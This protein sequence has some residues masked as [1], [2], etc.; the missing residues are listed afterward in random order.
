MSE[1][2]TNNAASRLAAGIGSGDTS[3]TV[4]TG[5]GALFPSPTGG[6][7]FRIVLVNLSSGEWEI[8]FCTAR[9]GDVLTI[10]RAQEDAV[11]HPARAFDA[12][13]PVELRP[14]AGF[15]SSLTVTTTNI[16][17]G[18]Y[19]YGTDTGAANV[20]TVDLTPALVGNPPPD[21]MEVHFYAANSNTT[22][23]TLNINGQGAQQIIKNSGQLQPND[24]IANR[25]VKV[26]WNPGQN[27]WY[28]FSDHNQRSPLARRA[29]A[30]LTSQGPIAA[31]QN[32]PLGTGRDV[33]FNNS[34]EDP[35]NMW[36][37]VNP[38]RLTV[39]SWANTVRC[40]A[41]VHFTDAIDTKVALIRKH[42]TVGTGPPDKIDCRQTG[43]GSVLNV[44][45]PPWPVNAGDYFTLIV[46][47]TVDTTIDVLGCY[48]GNDLIE[49]STWL[50]VEVL[51]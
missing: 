39:P 27:A 12:D 30:W 37:A 48:T 43:T 41:Q 44:S 7:F 17:S 28:L 46:A 9:S 16:Q 15:F 38:E 14:T 13:D 19:N 36:S 23:S 50:S 1:L 32:I 21:G 3:L 45:S 35:D 40:T 8:A 31:N 18:T 51:D 33:V 34:Y 22:A 6:D 2:F 25:L 42:Y 20:Y 29:L 49:S 4:K 47:A 24:I 10:Q 26:I 11:G 5:E